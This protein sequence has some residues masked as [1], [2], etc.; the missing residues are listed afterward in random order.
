V[1]ITVYDLFWKMCMFLCSLLFDLLFLVVFWSLVYW[2][3]FKRN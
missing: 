1:C 2:I 3:Y